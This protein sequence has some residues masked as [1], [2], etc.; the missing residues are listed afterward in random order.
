MDPDADLEHGKLLVT[1]GN[2][3]SLGTGLGPK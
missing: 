2:T 1:V 3:P